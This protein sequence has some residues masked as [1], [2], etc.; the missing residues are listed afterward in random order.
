MQNTLKI[1][2]IYEFQIKDKDGNIRD[3]WTVENLVVNAG[4]AQLALLTGDASAVPFTY[5]A[6]GTSTT[7]VAGAQ[8]ALVAEITT[9]GLGRSAGTVSRV[10]TTATNDTYQINKEWTATGA[11]TVEEIGVFNASSAG[12]M[13]SRALTTPK[14]LAVSER[15]N[16]TY[17]LVFANA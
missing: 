9:L 17:K 6:V 2:G 15:L 7:A 13:L 11:V 10:T 3:S 1:K 14:T 16:A 4:L 8:T 12:T 5:L